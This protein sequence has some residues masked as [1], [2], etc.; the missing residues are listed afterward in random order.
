MWHAVIA[1]IIVREYLSTAWDTAH[2]H[3]ALGRKLRFFQNALGTI[4]SPFDCY[5][6]HRGLKTLHVRM[7]QHQACRVPACTYRSL[8]ALVLHVVSQPVLIDRF[9]SSYL[10]TAFQARTYRPLIKLVHIDQ[11]I[12]LGLSPQT[13]ALA[14]AR[15]LEASPFVDGV[16]YPGLPSHPQHDLAR[17]QQRGYSGMVAFYIKGNLE[18]ATY[19][20]GRAFWLSRAVFRWE[21]S[22]LQRV[23]S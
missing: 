5:L 16:I 17:R 10:S 1:R 3:V 21:C 14:V 9:S 6:A 11:L 23:E 20:T 8:I 18:T 7:R 15:F 2:N 19:V 4:P 22:S 12:T 13:N